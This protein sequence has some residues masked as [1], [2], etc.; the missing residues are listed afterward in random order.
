MAHWLLGFLKYFRRFVRNRIS[1]RTE[2]EVIIHL[3]MRRKRC[4]AKKLQNN[5]ASQS[6]NKCLNQY[7]RPRLVASAV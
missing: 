3:A 1:N 4:I 5:T 2:V 7:E 6:C